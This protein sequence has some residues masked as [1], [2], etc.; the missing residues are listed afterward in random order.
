MGT[1]EMLTN[2]SQTHSGCVLDV[3]RGEWSVAKPC[4]RAYHSWPCPFAASEMCSRMHPSVTLVL[5]CNVV[6]KYNRGGWLMSAGLLGAFANSHACVYYIGCVGACLV[7]VCTCVCV[8]CRICGLSIHSV[9]ICVF[10][11]FTLSHQSPMNCSTCAGN[12]THSLQLVGRWSEHFVY[13]NLSA[14][15]SMGTLGSKY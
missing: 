2:V 13:P 15:T 4:V 8:T 5:S 10:C 7:S 6:I 14:V 12:R 11:V 9:C 1:S 3:E